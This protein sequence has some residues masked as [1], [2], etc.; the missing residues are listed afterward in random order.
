MLT[1]AA[2]VFTVSNF[3]E[4]LAHYRDALGFD[5]TFQWGAPPYYACLCRD[6]VQ[7]HLAVAGQSKLALGQG[8]LC[9]FVTDVDA[10]HAELV[11][12]GARVQTPPQTWPYGMRDFNVVD[13]DGNQLIFGMG[14]DKP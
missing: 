9:V 2:T 8:K 12:R 14:T 6:E 1:G 10:I 5:V 13:L 7:L 3:A 11:K 4:S